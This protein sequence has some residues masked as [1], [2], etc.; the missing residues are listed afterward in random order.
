MVGG[1]IMLMPT[2]PEPWSIQAAAADTHQESL[3][4]IE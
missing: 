3:L 1:T 2:A 4:D